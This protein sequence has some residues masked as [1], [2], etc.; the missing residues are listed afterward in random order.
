[1]EERLY[2]L[3]KVV[4][5]LMR[6]APKEAKAIVTPIY[7]SNCIAG[8]NISGEILRYMFCATGKIN[9]ILFDFGSRPKD[10]VDIVV[11]VLDNMA[12]RTSTYAASGKTFLLEPD[13]EVDSGDKL[14]ISISPRGEVQL[15]EVW[16]S[17][18]WTPK[19]KETTI[20]KLLIGDS[21][22]GI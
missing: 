8:E 9:K 5:R 4:E 20:Q 12:D 7:I 11:N 10:G 13:I 18:A 19:V 16:I 6:R 1:M 15:T 14:F 22:E 21:N 3:E 17:F 2:K